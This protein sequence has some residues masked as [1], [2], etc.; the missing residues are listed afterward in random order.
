MNATEFVKIARES[1]T[2][3]HFIHVSDYELAR[4]LRVTHSRS[5]AV[6]K[7]VWA[8]EARGLQVLAYG[9]D[10]LDNVIALCNDGIQRQYI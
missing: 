7:T 6:D 3:L 1:A 4:R 10:E 9:F 8:K 2:A 5:G